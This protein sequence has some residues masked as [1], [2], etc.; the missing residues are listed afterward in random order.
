MTFLFFGIFPTAADAFTMTGNLFIDSNRNN[1]KDAG[2]QNYPGRPSLSIAGGNSCTTASGGSMTYT[3]T[4]N[5]DGTYQYNI[6]AE[7][8]TNCF[9]VRVPSGYS[10]VN[11]P[12]RSFLVGSGMAYGITFNGGCTVTYSPSAP[13]AT[14]S[15][16]NFS[17]VNYAIVPNPTATPTVTATPTPSPTPTNPTQV[18]SPTLIPTPLATA[19]NIINLNFGINNLYPWIQTVCGDFRMDDGIENRVPA[20]QIALVANASCN[21]PGIAFSGDSSAT[22]GK[23]QPSSTNQIAG[24]TVYPE[25]YAP[26]NTGGIFSSYAYLNQKAQALGEEVIDLQTIC[27]NL[28]NCTLPNNLADGIYKA[29]GNVVLN[30]YTFANNSNHV[31]II[32]GNLTL[33]GNILVPQGSEST[34]L[35]STS[36][37]IIVPASVGNTLGI[38]TANFSGIFSTDQSFI[39]QS[40]GNC[41]DRKINFEGTLIV[42]AAQSGG[43]LQNQRDICADNA[44]TPIL[45]LTQRLDFVVNMPEFLKIQTITT[46]E[47][48]P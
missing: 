44:T 11:P 40:N 3:N 4:A 1:R 2:E 18:P 37:D 12:L 6:T 24:G 14:C 38:N 42:N 7:S 15:G 9:I 39:M 29:D 43:R 35:F 10:A 26:P 22:F 34:V 31:F 33:N 48:A 32:D 46:E 17:N 5:T 30:A 8:G 41:N 47:V 27:P 25:V 21:T 16:G 19:G 23:G 20:G 36:G 28:A 45:Q 13:D